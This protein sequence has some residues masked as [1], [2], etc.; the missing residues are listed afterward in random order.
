[1]SQNNP[2]PTYLHSKY[3][4]RNKQNTLFQTY[5]VVSEA[6]LTAIAAQRTGNL[7][8]G[9]YSNRR[10]I[11][12]LVANTTVQ[13]QLPQPLGPSNPG[14]T[15]SII[16]LCYHDSSSYPSKTSK[17][18]T[19]PLLRTLPISRMNDISLYRSPNPLIRIY[20]SSPAI[21]TDSY[22]FPSALD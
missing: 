13:N 18:P 19:I 17:S 3:A 11:A 5:G 6:I 9:R 4:H 14:R 15:E 1:M 22:S 10:D 2:F 16:S 12:S 21:T 8:F 20:H 7:H